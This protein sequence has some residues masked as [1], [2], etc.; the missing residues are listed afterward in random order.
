MQRPAV[1]LFVCA[2]AL[3]PVAAFADPIT[4]AQDKPGSVL[5]YQRLGPDDRQATLEAF[6]GAKITNLT[7]F[8]SLDAC[9][10]RET[11]ESDASHAKLGKTIADCQKELG[12]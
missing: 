10:L 3:A 2:L 1:A 7:A 8:D 9:T 11:T 12:K 4:P 5:K 6:T